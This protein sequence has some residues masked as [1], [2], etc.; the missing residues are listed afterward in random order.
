[1]DG[2]KRG[3]CGGCDGVCVAAS[4]VQ[5]VA[6]ATLSRNKAMI[7]GHIVRNF[8]HSAIRGNIASALQA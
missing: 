6:E 8:E 2:V 7:K 4:V 1:M 5:A 3:H